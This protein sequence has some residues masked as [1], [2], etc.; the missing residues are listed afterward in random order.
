M[1]PEPD[2]LAVAAQ[3]FASAVAETA[4]F[5]ARHPYYSDDASRAA[6]MLNWTRM[7]IRT[8]E[9]DI[10][11]DVDFPYFRVVDFRI[12]EGGDNA[13]QRYL[14]SPLQGGAA[15][16]VWGRRGGNRR[17]D[18]QLYAGLPWLPAGGRIA[19]VLSAEDL[20]VAADGT[21]EVFLGGPR[22]AR[23]W[24]ENPA[25]GTT[26]MVRQI[27]SDWSRERP[28]EIHIDRIDTVG[29]AKPA[30]TSA[31]M[32]ERLNRAAHNLNVVVPLWPEFVRRFYD[33][34]IPVNTLTP[35]LDPS[36]GGGVKERWMAF[37][38]FELADD[39]ALV[40]TTWPSGANYQGIQ[41]TDMWFASLEYANAQSSLSADQ[42]L[43]G[44]DGAFHFVVAGSDPGVQNWLDT[45]R[46][47]QGVILLRYD[48]MRGRAIPQEHWP[49]AQKVKLSE[50]RKYL[51]ADTPAY[52]AAQRRKELES[53]RRHVQQRYGV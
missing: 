19:S 4:Q 9:E 3:N 44:S 48:G 12:R 46:F 11:Q 31:A 17:L 15:Y 50:L 21:F 43:L 18:F 53:R 2:A 26:L 8:L 28:D 23:N 38:H 32:T 37:G 25:Q 27:F 14:V 33:E 22:R 47:R 35:P 36:A 49:R 20:E 10:V 39:E 52:N 29:A 13:D 34:S 5:V 42:A 41:L 6:G 7:I 45:Q 1:S 30:T 40:I 24:L 16:R 51:P